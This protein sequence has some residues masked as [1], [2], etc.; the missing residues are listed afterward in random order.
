MFSSDDFMTKIQGL[1]TCFLPKI[2][3]KIEKYPMII[4]EFLMMECIMQ[5]FFTD[6]SLLDMQLP[7]IFN[8]SKKR[9][10]SKTRIRLVPTQTLEL[11]NS[12]ITNNEFSRIRLFLTISYLFSILINCSDLKFHC[13]FEV[14]KMEKNIF[15]GWKKICSTWNTIITSE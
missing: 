13:S 2:C 10:F 15:P 7:S 4:I 14:K 1:A 9:V 12:E 5:T 11:S 8:S 3:T 6:S